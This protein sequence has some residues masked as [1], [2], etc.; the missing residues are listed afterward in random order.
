MISRPTTKQKA[1]SALEHVGAAVERHAGA[2]LGVLLLLLFVA[3]VGL[4]ASDFL[5]YDELVIIH[6]SLFPHWHDIWNFY[7]SGLDTIGLLYAL[8]IH[9]LLK[10]PISAE[11]SSRLPAM[12]AFLAMLWCA[13]VFVRRRYAAVYAFAMLMLLGTFPL[14]QYSA[15]AKSYAFEL[16]G[17]AFAMIC[18]QSA[19]EG[20]GRPW[21]VLG[22]WFGLVL[23][24][25]SHSFAVFLFVPFAVAQWL[26]DYQRKKVDWPV[27]AALVLFPAGLLPVLRGELLA[28]KLYGGTFWS[29][30]TPSLLKQTYIDYFVENWRYLLILFVAALIVAMLLRERRLRAVALPEER[31]ADAPLERRGFTKPEWVFIAM[32]AALPLY[33]FPASYLLHAYRADYVACFAIGLAMLLVALFAEHGEHTRMAGVVLLLLFAWV[34]LRNDLET[35]P[36]G[37]RALVHPSRVHAQLETSYD[38]TPWI[39]L[40]EGS[41]LPV[42]AGDH[43]TYTQMDWYA[44]PE[45]TRRLYFLTDFA[46]VN[47]YPLSNTSQRN[48]LLFGKPLSYQTMDIGDF[49]PEHPHFLLVAGKMKETLWLAPYLLRQEQVGNASLLFLGPGFDVPDVYDVQ[50]GRLPKF[51][52]AKPLTP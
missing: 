4:A 37:L 35:F 31:A 28:S 30:P 13:F 17:V 6:V 19:M 34:T 29:Q 8:S 10:V 22:I 39:K 50:F 18:W 32:L 2:L 20:R 14:L 38:S 47:R 27:W 45:L 42:L 7:A 26:R 15:F 23:A 9:D 36:Q 44:P 25:Y 48:F 52:K 43:N 11:I 51:P 40:L 12:A 16:A 33:V 24:I 41:T 49:L 21:S 3:L 5:W 1:D 46:E